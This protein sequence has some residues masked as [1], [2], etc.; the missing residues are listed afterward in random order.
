MLL[1]L[2]MDCMGA[3]SQTAD[4]YKFLIES[5]LNPEIERRSAHTTVHVFSRSLEHAGSQQNIKQCTNIK[6]APFTSILQKSGF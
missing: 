4:F 1:I 5:V 2:I 3:E 6:S